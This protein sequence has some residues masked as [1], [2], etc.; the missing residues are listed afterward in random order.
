MKMRIIVCAMLCV[1]SVV[2]AGGI[3]QGI[4]N[5]VTDADTLDGQHGAYYRNAA[6][7]TNF[8]PNDIWTTNMTN[9][10]TFPAGIKGAN[11]AASNDYAT[12]G[13]LQSYAYSASAFYLTSNKTFAVT[14]YGFTPTNATYLASLT[15]STNAGSINIPDSGAT[16]S[17]FYA[18]VF[19]NLTVTELNGG[20]AQVEIWASENSA[21]NMS[22]KPE[23]YLIDTV[24]SNIV[25]AAEFGTTI[26]VIGTTPT[27]YKAT[28]PYATISTNNP[29]YMALRLKSTTTANKNVTIYSGANRASHFE[30]SLPSSLFTADLLKLDGS[31]KMTG[32]LGMG[33]NSITNVPAIT[34][35]TNTTVQ[36]TGALNG[37][38]GVGWTVAGTNFWLLFE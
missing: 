33:G 16:N 15:L 1:C 2:L 31:R 25:E 24:N 21:G 34:F 32:A 8:P 26:E 22:F 10:V 37:T 3:N 30:L 7:S 29:C 4:N 27:L 28:V 9:V 36:F 35:V 5:P 20:V 17:Y 11:G 23:G 38:N 19:T 14:N 13:Q 6:N 12:F 18:A